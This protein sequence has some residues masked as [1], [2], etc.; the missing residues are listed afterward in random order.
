M[1]FSDTALASSF[2]ETYG[3][4]AEDVLAAVSVIILKSVPL[5]EWSLPL[6]R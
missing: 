6:A 2:D 4:A 3:A 1:E 5:N